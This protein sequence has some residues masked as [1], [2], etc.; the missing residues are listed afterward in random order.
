MM[1]DRHCADDACIYSQGHQ[2]RRES[3]EDGVGGRGEPVFRQIQ[4]CGRRARK[5][6]EARGITIRT[7][8]SD[9]GLWTKSHESRGNLNLHQHQRQHLHLL[10]IFLTSGFALG[11]WHGGRWRGGKC[12]V[13][14]SQFAYFELVITI[15]ARARACAPYTF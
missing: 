4:G 8:N 5:R 12:W 3:W 1:F 6:V 9:Q 13:G 10:F 7:G 11:L 2:Y 14:G 15:G